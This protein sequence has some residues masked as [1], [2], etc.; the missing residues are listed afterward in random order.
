MHI[1]ENKLIRAIRE[2]KNIDNLDLKTIDE[3]DRLY[4]KF[5]PEIIDMAKKAK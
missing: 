2:K 4:M 3:E 1:K 5:D